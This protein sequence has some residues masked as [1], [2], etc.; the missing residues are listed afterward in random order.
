MSAPQAKV[1][2][3]LLPVEE[4]NP[5]TGDTFTNGTTPVD[6]DADGVGGTPGQSKKG[7]M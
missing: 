6:D 4:A 2:S 3:T 7:G 1:A 5:P